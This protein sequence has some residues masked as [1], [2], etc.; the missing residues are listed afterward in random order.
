MRTAL[1]TVGVGCLPA[2]DLLRTVPGSREATWVSW[3]ILAFSLAGLLLHRRLPPVSV[4]VTQGGCLAW[5]L[6][7]HVGELLN[8]PAMLSLYSVAVTGSRRRTLRIAAVTSLLA[9]TAAVLSGRQEGRPVPS[10]LL[11]MAVPLAPLLLGEVIRGRRELAAA[12]AARRLRE[13][14]ILLA[15]ELH[16]VL[17]HTVS[18]MTVQASVALEALDRRPELAR[19][20]LGQV[21]AS[22]RE[23]MRELRATVALLREN[24]AAPPTVPAPRLAD[25]PGLL[26]HLPG[27]LRITLENA[28]GPPLPQAVE[29]AA[30]R[31]VQEALTNVVKHSAARH[32]TVRLAAVDGDLAVTVDDEGPAAAAPGPAGFGL[33]GMRER[34]TAL[35]GT[36][37]YGPL[38]SGGFRVSARLPAYEGGA[39]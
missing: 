36:L 1:I 12:Q 11:E 20:A 4:A 30:Y 37:S 39:A 35:G 31:I 13:E 17:A 25:L 16:D 33:L 2:A 26:A 21:G 5:T 10:P 24:P 7:G 32:A 19:E 29:L 28:A 22:G 8:L 6:Y 38:P 9:V 27:T 34:A 3:L 14:R 18:A 23:A 15:R